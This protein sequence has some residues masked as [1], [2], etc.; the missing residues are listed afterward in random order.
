MRRR[1]ADGHAQPHA[2][3]AGRQDQRQAF[4]RL[5]PIA[6][7]D[8]EQEA[9]H[10]QD[11]HLPAAMHPPCERREDRRDQDRVPR[12]GVEVFDL[13]PAQVIDPARIRRLLQQR[14]DR[15]DH[16][17]QRGGHRVEDPGEVVLQPVEPGLRR[18]AHAQ[19][20]FAQA[21]SAPPSSG[22]PSSHSVSQFSIP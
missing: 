22:R 5:V 6:L 1:D 11:R 18:V 12:L 10:D 7:V 16:H 14:E 2:D 8:D 21:S 3:H 13:R 4:G 20:A 9:D 17:L 15:L 19:L